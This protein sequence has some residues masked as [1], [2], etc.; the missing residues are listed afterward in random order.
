MISYFS[1]R[2]R[3]SF[4]PPRTVPFVNKRNRKNFRAHPYGMLWQ[5]LTACARL[6]QP[7]PKPMFTVRAPLM[8]LERKGKREIAPPIMSE[9]KKKGKRREREREREEVK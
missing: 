5:G 9:K 7:L 2:A 1:G 8:P 3:E 4:V 6:R